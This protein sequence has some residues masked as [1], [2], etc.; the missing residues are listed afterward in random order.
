MEYSPKPFA[1]SSKQHVLQRAPSRGK[2][3]ERTLFHGLQ[4]WMC[5]LTEE[6]D[7]KQPAL[8]QHFLLFGQCVGKHL[9]LI[10]V[11]RLIHLEHKLL[12]R[13]HILGKR[14][15]HLRDVLTAAHNDKLK[16]PQMIVGWS[17]ECRTDNS[18]ENLVAHFPV[19][20]IAI[21]A[22]SFQYF[23][24]IHSVIRL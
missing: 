21:R 5:L 9:H 1:G 14:G 4:Q 10:L 16:L 6:R 18:F 3:I 8:H 22:T 12:K 7:N 11:A 2:V 19:R 24:E 17:F 15:N 20:E 23:V 13:G